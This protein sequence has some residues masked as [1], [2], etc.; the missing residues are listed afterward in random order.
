MP[1]ERQI[2]ELINKNNTTTKFT[3]HN[4]VKGLLITSNKNG[5]SIFLPATGSVTNGVCLS[6]GRSGYYWSTSG[7]DSAAGALN[8]NEDGMI[9][10][11]LLHRD[12]GAPIRPVRSK[13]AATTS[14][15]SV[16]ADQ[17]VAKDG[18]YIIDGRLVIVK[19]GKQYNAQGINTK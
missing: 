11:G 6:K 17:E 18:K 14:I 16:V 1:T 3:S 15:N 13:K 7:F 12:Q 9:V 8:F 10:N 19:D 4:G 2:S 5:M